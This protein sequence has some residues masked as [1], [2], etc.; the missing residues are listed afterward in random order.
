MHVYWLGFGE[1]KINSE[2]TTIFE[3][4]QKIWHFPAVVDLKMTLER[5][6]E[7]Q[8]MG[9]NTSCCSPLFPLFG[10]HIDAWFFAT[11]RLLFQIA[12]WSP[13][14]TQFYRALSSTFNIGSILHRIVVYFLTNES[15]DKLVQQISKVRRFFLNNSWPANLIN[16]QF[17]NEIYFRIYEK[18]IFDM[19]W[20]P[21]K[22]WEGHEKP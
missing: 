2:V 13:D 5:W 9:N 18:E 22:N 6:E 20:F 11:I 1:L 3:K 19:S 4:V 16:N 7:S 21:A 14:H 15:I 12:V 8:R 10:Y 17:S